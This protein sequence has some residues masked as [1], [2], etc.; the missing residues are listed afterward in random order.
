MKSELPKQVILMS[1]LTA[2]I[3]SEVVTFNIIRIETN[4]E[5]KIETE[6][7]FITSSVPKKKTTFF[8]HYYSLKVE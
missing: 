1:Q 5:T 8:S 4:L 7:Q 2:E 6:C 3:N